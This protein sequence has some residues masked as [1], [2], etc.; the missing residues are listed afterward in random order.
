MVEFVRQSTALFRTD[1]Y[2]ENFFNRRIY[3]RRLRVP[4]L[5]WVFWDYVT[6][7]PLLLAFHHYFGTKEFIT[8][9]KKLAAFYKAGKTLKLEQTDY[10]MN[11]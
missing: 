5:T 4:P 1:L 3:F 11:C 7:N 9:P 10:G 2:V 6:V 8:P